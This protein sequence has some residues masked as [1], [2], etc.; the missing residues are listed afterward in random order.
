MFSYRALFR[1]AWEI[2]WRHK[3]LW[4][5]GFF[6]SLVAGGGSW[7]YQVLTQNFNQGLIDGSYIRLANILALGEVLK[8]F[9]L[10]LINIFSY[11]LWTIVNILSVLLISAVFII[12]FI[13][14]AVTS[15]AALVGGA[16]RLLETRKKEQVLSIRA[17]LTEGHRYFWPVLGLNFLIRVLV[18]G[19]L[20]IISLPLLFMV[21][22]DTGALAAVYTVLFI[23]FIPVAMGLSLLIKY[24]IAYE[25][26]DNKRLVSSLE[27][28][29]RLFKKNWLISVEAAVILFLI[30]FVAS[31]ILVIIISLF[32]LPLLILGLL[33][34]IG[35]IV[36]LMVLLGIVVIVVFGAL[37]TTFQ[38]AAWTNLFLRLKNEGG[39][40]KLERIFGRRS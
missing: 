6:A 29:W 40:A 5:F 11:D 36:I 3:Y 21:I 16:K 27:H 20:F 17:G 38:T 12:F 13:W 8:N 39:L 9:A 30:N 24:A 37:M 4:F 22:E 19:V 31:V 32:L 18:G 2:S 35:W 33:F 1:Q 23:I 34:K 28:G 25:V 10:G 26:L 14:L 15:Q 7:E